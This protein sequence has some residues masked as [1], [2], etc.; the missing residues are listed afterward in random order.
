MITKR[1]IQHFH[2]A[3]D[4]ALLQRVLS[5]KGHPVQGGSGLVSMCAE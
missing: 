3:R 1:W 2:I 4:A 5:G